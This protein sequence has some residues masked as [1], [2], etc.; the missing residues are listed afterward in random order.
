MT[1]HIALRA[2]L[3]G[4]SLA[5]LATPA[6]AQTR[7][8]ERPQPSAELPLCRDAEP[9]ERCRTRSGEVRVRR[10]PAERP[11]PNALGGGDPGWEVRQENTRDI[12]RGPASGRTVRPDAG[13]GDSFTG[14]ETVFPAAPRGDSFGG[15]DAG[16]V[17]DP[18]GGRFGGEDPGWVR[19]PGAGDPQTPQAMECELCDD[20]EDVPQGP[21]DN[22]PRPQSPAPQE[23]A[24]EEEDCEWRNPSQGPDQ[25]FCDE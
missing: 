15:E 21:I 6:L 17:R 5:M 2:L 19:P 7:Q 18:D 16:W 10:G 25:E 9:G 11:A 13:D 23:P 20:D 22:T 3:L 1:R 12:P 14:E 4:A 24:G 8:I